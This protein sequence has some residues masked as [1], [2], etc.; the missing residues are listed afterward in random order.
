MKELPVKAMV[1]REA[2]KRKIRAADVAKGLGIDYTSAR[3]LFLRPT[4]QVQRLADL[5]ELFEYNFFREL[6]QQLPYDAPYYNDENELNSAT[7][8]IGKLKQRIFE[9]EIENRT[10]KEAFQQALAR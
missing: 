4:M 1:Q 9:L 2:R 10:L 5:S 3:T 7:D 6:A 8:E